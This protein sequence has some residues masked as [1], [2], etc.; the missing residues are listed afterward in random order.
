MPTP[1]E[2]NAMGKGGGE[3]EERRQMQK[4][5]IPFAGA[6]QGPQGRARFS[7]CYFLG[8]VR[9]KFTMSQISSGFKRPSSPIILPL[10]LLMME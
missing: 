4:G 2:T 7:E 10:P 1:P 8:R 3:Q 5:S 6:W 9:T